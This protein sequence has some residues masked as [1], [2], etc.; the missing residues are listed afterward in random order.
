MAI[1]WRESIALR[2]NFSSRKGRARRVDLQAN[3]DFFARGSPPGRLPRRLFSR[4]ERA[5][6]RRRGGNLAARGSAPGPRPPG[7]TGALGSRCAP[8]DPAQTDAKA[9]PVQKGRQFRAKR[10][11][12]MDRARTRGAKGCSPACAQ[13]YAQATRSRNH[14]ASHRLAIPIQLETI[15]LDVSSDP[16]TRVGQFQ[17]C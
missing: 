2:G 12:K 7:S 8:H 6:V 17:L 10:I 11:S 13:P 14:I 4:G 3:F 15:E 9:P 1:T 5:L 16:K